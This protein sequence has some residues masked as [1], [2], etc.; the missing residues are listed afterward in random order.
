M[1]Q[2]SIGTLESARVGI[3]MGGVAFRGL[4]EDARN[5][6]RTKEGFQRNAVGMR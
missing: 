6:A 4:R 2:K 1:C 5:L 3:C